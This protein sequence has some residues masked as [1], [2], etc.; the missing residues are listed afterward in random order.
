[1][2]SS[3]ISRII[4][5]NTGPTGP[6]GNTGPIG[7]T[8]TGTGKTGS[9]GITGEWVRSI[10]VTDNG[11]INFNTPNRSFGI[12]GTKGN[13][14]LTGTVFGQNVGEGLSLFFSQNGYTSN[15]RGIS[16]IGN[17]SA[18]VTGGTIKVI[19]NDVFYGIDLSSSIENDRLVYSETENKINSTRIALGKTYGDFSF[20]NTKGITPGSLAVYGEIHGFVVSLNG[21][22]SV[23]NGLTLSVS[24]GGVYVITTPLK[25]NA[26]SLDGMTYNSNE[27]ISATLFINGNSIVKLPSNLFFGGYTYSSIFGCGINIMNIMTLDGGQNWFASIIDRGYGVSGCQDLEGLGSCCGATS[28]TDY[29]TQDEC[30]SRGGRWNAFKGCSDAVCSYESLCCSNYDCVSGIE[31]EECLKFGGQYY[32]GIT[33]G[34]SQNENAED[35]TLRTC[36]NPNFNSTICCV[37][38]ECIPDVTFRL[39]RDFYGGVPLEGTCTDVNCAGGGLLG[40]CCPQIP[41]PPGSINT[42]EENINAIQCTKLGGIWKSHNDCDLCETTEP[43]GACCFDDSPCVLLTSTVCAQQGG[44]FKGPGTNCD[45][46]CSIDPILGACCKGGECLERTLEQCDALAGAFQG[47]QTTCPNDACIPSGPI[48]ACC[49]NGVCS[50]KTQGQCIAQNGQ[51]FEGQACEPTT[52]FQFDSFGACCRGLNCTMELVQDCVSSDGFFAGAGSTCAVNPCS[53]NPFGACC[54]LD[55]AEC[56]VISETACAAKGSNYR[57][58]QGLQ[59]NVVTCGYGSCCQNI[60]GVGA[61]IGGNSVLGQAEAECV[62]GDFVRGKTC[63]DNPCEIGLCCRQRQSLC[64]VQTRSFCNAS[65]PTN[66]TEFILGVTSCDNNPCGF[67]SCCVPLGLGTQC[68]ANTSQFS[69]ETVLQ[70][71]YTTQPCENNPCLLGGCC[72]PLNEIFT[73]CVENTFT[74]QQCINAPTPTGLPATFL[75]VGIDCSS[76]DACDT[77][78]PTTGACCQ[79]TDCSQTT[80]AQCS[81]TFIGINVPCVPDTCNSGT[82]TG[83]CCIQDDTLP[84]G[85]ACIDDQTPTDCITQNGIFYGDDTTCLNSECPCGEPPITDRHPCCHVD[86]DNNVI[87]EMLTVQEC[88]DF[89]GEYH[90]NLQECTSDL[91]VPSGACTG[92]AFYPEFYGTQGELKRWDCNLW[93]D[94]AKLTGYAFYVDGVPHPYSTESYFVGSSNFE[95]W[96]NQGGSGSDQTVQIIPVPP[97][98]VLGE[99]ITFIVNDYFYVFLPRYV[100]S[101]GMYSP[102]GL[103]QYNFAANTEDNP[104]PQRP[105]ACACLG[106]GAECPTNESRIVKN[107]GECATI[108]DILNG[109]TGGNGQEPFGVSIYN[110]T[111]IG[112]T[113]QDCLSYC[114]SNPSP[115]P[116]PTLGNYISACRQVQNFI[117]PVL[118]RDYVDDFF[119]CNIRYPNFVMKKLL[120]DRRNSFIRMGEMEMLM[121][122]NCDNIP[123]DNLSAW[124]YRMQFPIYVSLPSKFRG[125]LIHITAGIT[126]SGLMSSDDVVKEIANISVGNYHM[127]S[128]VG[129]D[130]QSSEQKAWGAIGFPIEGVHTH[131]V[132]MLVTMGATV[133]DCTICLNKEDEFLNT[134]F[135]RLYPITKKD[136]HDKFEENFSNYLK[137]AIKID[138][139]YFGISDVKQVTEYIDEQDPAFFVCN[140]FDLDGTGLTHGHFYIDTIVDD[141][142]VTTVPRNAIGQSPWGPPAG[143]SDLNFYRFY[144]A[145][146]QASGQ[147]SSGGCNT[148]LTSNFRTKTMNIND[149]TYTV[150]CA[151]DPNPCDEL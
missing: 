107:P 86:A 28:C 46:H 97:P 98:Y 128:L 41:P 67:G 4:L 103:F 73:Q 126:A 19:P 33:C 51:F 95:D 85:Y 139:Q 83:A 7:P 76:P 44:E 52:C 57:F 121:E 40:A 25:W 130:D 147:P 88:N 54:R 89:F 8:G 132:E 47:A 87:C 29:L 43:T 36:Y 72:I 32:E 141:N 80:Q 149:K 31:Q 102:S 90:P 64:Q 3:S 68:I 135:M 105:T 45:V 74:E 133:S 62:S 35:N 79:G 13:T 49:V 137:K 81:G 48:G 11:S 116:H 151:G 17:L 1:M 92:G 42:C 113:D 91:C 71:T 134:T 16:F 20:S 21:N 50:I 24:N 101:S 77:T 2:G 111:C 112:T 122:F 55:S 58:H 144:N 115:A 123:P 124:S 118:T 5:G 12:T 39:C 75:G 114:Y 63:G 93:K 96:D 78:P 22:D 66:P 142:I 9:V 84:G 148:T 104:P 140:P 14:G 70:G 65:D 110:S 127:A 138:N 146:Y 125:K 145:Y 38:G 23:D 120:N 82:I 119:G 30:N 18:Q 99:F 10:N 34:N 60:L 59:C 143:R 53:G 117:P 131:S 109:T 6:T 56:S 136:D 106:G 37:D 100:K 108:D 94:T 150:G 69:C 61:C 26:I 27:L 129:I 15:I